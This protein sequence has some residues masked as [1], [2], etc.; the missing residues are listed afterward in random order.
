MKNLFKFVI[1]TSKLLQFIAQTKIECAFVQVNRLSKSNA[2]TTF[3][4]GAFRY[5]CH[6]IETVQ[7]KCE[8][9]RSLAEHLHGERETS[10]KM[11]PC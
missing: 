1:F 7:H 6:A 5:K 3:V 11:K 4:Y 10:C 9:E 8:C 2:L